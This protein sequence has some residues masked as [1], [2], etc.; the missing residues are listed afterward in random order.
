[1]YRHVERIINSPVAI[2][3]IGLFLVACVGINQAD[4]KIKDEKVVQLIKEGVYLF[5]KGKYDEALEKFSLAERQSRVPEDKIKVADIISK[6]GFVLIYKQKFKLAL[7]Y[8]DRSL[9]INRA[10]NNKPGLANN[11]S[12][13]G[14]IYSDTGK[15]TEAIRFFEE[16]LAIHK[17]LDDKAGIATTLNNLGNLH[18]YL[19]DYQESILLFNQSLKISEEIRNSELISNT[20]I[21][22]GA[23][24]FRLRNY[25]QSVEY[26]DRALSIADKE[27]QDSIKATALNLKGVVYREQGN[28]EKALDNYQGALKINKRLKLKYEIAINLNTIGEI[29]KE[30]GRYDDALRYL[31]ESLDMTEELKNQLIIAITM[32]YIGEIRFK[33]G[34]YQEA[35]NLYNESLRIFEKLGAKDR[36]AR[37]FNHIAYVKGEMKEWDAATENFD[38]AITIY[39]E[40]GDREWIRISLFGEG[41]YSEQKGD[42]VAAEKNYKE[43]VD[44]FESIRRDVV[45]GE[46]GQQIFSEVNVKIYEKLVSLLIREGKTEEALEYIQ[47][48]MSKSLRDSLL[49]SGISSFDDNIRGQL[50]KYDELSKRETSINYEIASERSKSSPNPEKIDNMI[51]TLAKTREEFNKVTSQLKKE[52]PRIYSVLGISPENLAYLRHSGRL[53]KSLVLLQ[54]FVTEDETYIFTVGQSGL[55]VKTV[56]IKKDDLNRMVYDFRRLIFESSSLGADKLRLRPDDVAKNNRLLGKLSMSLYNYFVKPV[57]GDIEGVDIIGIIP[58]GVLNF[59]PFQA[60]SRQKADGGFEFLLEQKNLVYLTNINQ[61]DIALSEEKANSFQSTVA[62]GDPDLNDRE[63]DLPY[64]KKEVLAIKDIFP[65]ALIFLGDKATKENFKKNWG[66]YQIVHLSA[67]GVLNE[68]GEFILLAPSGA[69]SLSTTDI[70]ELPPVEKVDL[71]TLSACSTAIDP[72]QKNPTGTQL[73]TLALSFEWIK[74]PSVIATLWDI[75]D[76]GTA[77]LMRVFYKNL[78]DGKALY[79]AFREAQIEMIRRGDKYSH[80]YYWAPFILFG[81]W[82]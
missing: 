43:A 25:Q 2:L 37:S 57:K 1:M 46:E 12:Y 67:H 30:L 76:Q 15:Y 5:D 63:L 19:G 29:Y 20:L 34:N 77:N 78:K 66:K 28:Y 75:S 10:L 4:I 32:S 16:A 62:F 51:K 23:I 8:Y 47:R 64:S 40:L 82:E 71:V 9:E 31:E 42:L 68:G 81:S 33:Q 36:I 11:Y 49:K 55:K 59:L 73:A 13:V 72:L 18:S 58:F 80:P 21:Y 45:G 41:L 54:Y 3:I 39:K 7:S 35:L 17:A 38:K 44:V 27:G 6:G 53:S 50:R 52:Y 61:L 74:V 69:G 79:T 48:S 70:T 65:N 14:K 60:L 24:N 26:I 56:S 22:I